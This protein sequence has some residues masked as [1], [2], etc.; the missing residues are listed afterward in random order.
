MLPTTPSRAVAAA[1]PG[2]GSR[3]PVLSLCIWRKLATTLCLLANTSIRWAKKA[4]YNTMFAG[5]YL[6][7]VGKESWLQHYVCWQIPQSGG[8]RKLATALC[9]LANTSIRWAKTAGYNTMF[10]GKYLNQVGKDS[11]LQH[12]VCWQIHQSGGQRK[13]A[14]TLCLLANTSIRWAKKAGYN[15]M[16]AGK[17]LNQVGKESWL[18][19]YVCWQIPQSGGQRKLAITL[20]LLA[21]T[22]IRWAKKA[23]YNTMFAGKSLN[24]VGKES[25]LQHYVCWQIPQ[26]GGQRKLAT[27]LCLLANTSIRWAKKAGYST[28]FAGKYLNQVGKDSWLQHYVC[29]QIPQSGGQRQLATTLCLL[30]NTSIR[31]AKKAGYNTMFAGKYLNQVGKESWLQHYVCWQIPQSGGQRKLATTLCLLA[32]P[33]IRWAKKAGYN[34]MFAGKYLN[35]VG[36]ESWLQHYVCWQIPQSGGQR[37]LATTLCLLANPSIRWAKKAGYNTMFAGKSLNQVGKESW[38]QHYVCWQIPQ[39]GGQRKLATT[40][41]LLANPSIR[42]AKKAGYNTMFAGKSLN[43]VGKESWLQHYVRWQ[44]P[45]SGGQRKLATTLCL[46]ANPSIRW[47]KKAG[48]NTMFAGKYLNQVGKEIRWAVA[49]L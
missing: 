41:C 18:Q 43:Q 24:Q 14:T 30:A 49:H 19:H 29:W 36:K 48:Y 32:N 5:K 42:W 8:Q 45:Q 10:A 37:K 7:Q 35:Q 33:S 26:S 1:H 23:G 17:Y 2:R 16:F 46:L 15:T 40:L 27:T 12:Y 20:C 21:N 13:L 28:M 22:S 39:S 11:W 34:T 31:W 4:G 6:N 25:W 44:I 9:L 3:S 47:A 38:L